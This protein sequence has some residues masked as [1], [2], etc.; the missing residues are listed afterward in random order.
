GRGAAGVAACPHRAT[1]P[2]A[3]PTPL[4]RAR[5][6]D[7]GGAARHSAAP[8]GEGAARSTHPRARAR[9]APVRRELPLRAVRAGARAG[10]AA[11]RCGDGRSRVSRCDPRHRPRSAVG[12]AARDGAERIP[13]ALEVTYADAG[14]DTLPEIVPVYSPV[15]RFATPLVPAVPP[16]PAKRPVPPVIMPGSS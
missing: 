2:G 16:A 11:P 4:R 12:R 6:G 9:A 3:D 10:R 8:R 5:A 13:R 7:A 14:L 1:S 15:A